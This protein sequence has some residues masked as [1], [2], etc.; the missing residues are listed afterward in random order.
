MHHMTPPAQAA[1]PE[2]WW[3][4][5]NVMYVNWLLTINRMK[6]QFTM[7]EFP[8]VNDYEARPIMLTGI[9]I[10]AVNT[11]RIAAFTNDPRP[12]DAM[13]RFLNDELFVD[14]VDPANAHLRCTETLHVPSIRY[15]YL[16]RYCIDNN[17]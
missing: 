1:A 15:Q 5:D 2:N 14:S 11:R 9:I 8:M 3:T 4:V 13:I 7:K 16:E 17:V 12:S 6:H 10:P